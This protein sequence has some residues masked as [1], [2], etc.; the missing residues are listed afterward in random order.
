MAKKRYTF[1]LD[2]E[3]VSQLDELAASLGLSR[4]GMVNYLISVAVAGSTA[5]LD[6][7]TEAVKG[8]TDI[9]GDESQSFFD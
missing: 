3:R 9:G 4:S 1:S 7:A 5:A 8:S 6:A 2:E